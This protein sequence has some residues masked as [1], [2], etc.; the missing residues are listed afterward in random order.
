[1]RLFPLLT[2][3]LL[4][5]MFGA[6]ACKGGRPA[7]GAHVHGHARLN[8]ALESAR[9]LEMEFEAPG[10]SVF[11]FEHAP[12]TAQEKQTFA[13]R[14]RLLEKEPATLFP[15]AAAHGCQIASSEFHSGRGEIDGE[16]GEHGE[17]GESEAEHAHE[18]EHAHGEGHS[19]VSVR[20]SL[21]CNQDLSGKELELSFFDALPNLEQLEIVTLS[22]GAQD[23]VVIERGKRAVIKLGQ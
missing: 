14:S 11:G 20:Y 13:D 8:V 18:D 2:L 5:V 9:Q 19:E 16:H 12:A 21:R 4:P 1:M 23:S 22:E 7:E 15:F 17:H 3:I 6:L 10:A